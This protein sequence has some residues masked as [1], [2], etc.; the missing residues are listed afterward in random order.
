MTTTET[1]WLNMHV[2]ISHHGLLGK[3][4]TLNS[5]TQEIFIYNYACSFLFIKIYPWILFLFF[6]KNC[7]KLILEI[8]MVSRIKSEIMI[9]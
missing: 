5:D 8:N 4:N 7:L 1:L 6:T 3:L 2:K 9:Y